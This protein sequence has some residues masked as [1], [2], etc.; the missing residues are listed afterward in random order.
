MHSLDLVSKS[1]ITLRPD[2]E[3]SKN[4]M[5]HYKMYDAW[6]WNDDYSW[7]DEEI[8]YNFGSDCPRP[9]KAGKTYCSYLMNHINLNEPRTPIEKL[10]K[11]LSHIKRSLLR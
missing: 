5:Q 11:H 10:K 9:R 1:S 6:T 4:I 3:L 8:F 7:P 2:Q